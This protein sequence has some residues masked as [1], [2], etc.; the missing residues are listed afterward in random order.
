M[1]ISPIFLFGCTETAITS[2]MLSKVCLG[3]S[4]EE[5][6]TQLGRPGQPTDNIDEAED[7]FTYE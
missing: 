6:D 1:L 4:L 7:V 3:M 5:I 2:E